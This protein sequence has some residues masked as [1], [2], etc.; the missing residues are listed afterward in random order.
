MKMRTLLL[1]AA[2]LITSGRAFAQLDQVTKG[3]GLSNQSQLSDSKIASG[4]KEALQIGADD[5]VKL[6]GEKRWVF[7]KPGHQNSTTQKSS[8]VAKRAWNDWL[9][10]KN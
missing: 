7:W 3:L 5:A 10:V 8:A 2:L 4:L 6:T 9:S 1:T